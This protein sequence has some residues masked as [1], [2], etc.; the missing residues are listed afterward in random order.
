MSLE[1]DGQRDAQ[2]DRIEAKLDAL[3]Q[4]LAEDDEDEGPTHD[5]EGNA[6]PARRQD[7]TEL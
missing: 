7:D 5:L 4:A 1:E 3:I 2:L 6:L